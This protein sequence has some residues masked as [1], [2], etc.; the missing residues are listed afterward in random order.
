[1]SL[2][3]II[4]AAAAAAAAAAAKML[5]RCLKKARKGRPDRSYLTPAVWWEDSWPFL[6]QYFL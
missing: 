4:S 6:S 3:L 5:P 2:L 1:V